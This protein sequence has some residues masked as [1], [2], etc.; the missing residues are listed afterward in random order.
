MAFEMSWAGLG[1]SCLGFIVLCSL[2]GCTSGAELARQRAS[3]EY[4]CVISEN[5][6]RW[7]SSGPD[8]YEI[9]KVNAC[10]RVVTYAC[11]E[12]TESCIKESDDRRR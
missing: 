9:Y 4:D 3:R 1:R 8:G 11:K 7:I 6:V 5:R 10:G 12:L 2:S